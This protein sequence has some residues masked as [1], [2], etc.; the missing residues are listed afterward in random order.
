MQAC[1]LHKPA[2]WRHPRALHPCGPTAG[3]TVPEISAP[4]SLTSDAAAGAPGRG[5]AIAALVLLL[6]C[7]CQAQTPT[8]TL[9]GCVYGSAQI[10][11]GGASVHLR[12]ENRDETQSTVTDD[13]GCF[14]FANL[15]PDVY[16]VAAAKTGFH[17]GSDTI[18]LAP[19]QEGEI[20]IDL[21]PED[22]PQNA[23]ALRVA[24]EQREIR[25]DTSA[26]TDSVGRREL[27]AL[28]L[29]DDPLRIISQTAGMSLNLTEEGATVVNVG[30]ARS[31]N[32]NVFYDGFISLNPRTGSELIRPT[33]EALEAVKTKA[34]ANSAQYAK[35]AGLVATVVTKR[36]G[37][38]YH[39][40]LFAYFRNDILNARNYFD[41]TKPDNN[42]A[43]FGAVLGGPVRIP[44]LYQGRHRTFFF[45]AFE[46]FRES[47]GTTRI[48]GVPTALERQ[49]D[50]S[51]STGAGGVPVVL[52]D[53]FN[54]GAT[55]PGNQ[56]P[57]SLFSP[58]AQAVDSYFPL[59]NLPGNFNNYRATVTGIQRWANLL[60]KLDHRFSAA[61]E[62]SFRLQT[63]RA[64]QDVPFGGSDLGTFGNKTQSNTV[65][66]GMIWYHQFSTQFFNEVRASLQ[67]AT[68]RDW[69]DPGAPDFAAKSAL[70]VYTFTGMASFGYNSSV[71]GN[72]ATTYL[73]FADCAT[74]I[75]SR[76][77]LKWGGE[78]QPGQV[79]QS[80]T[81]NTRGTI[82][83]QDKT[84]TSKAYADFLMGLMRSSSIAASE[85]GNYV[86]AA[87]FGFFVQ[88]TYRLSSRLTLNLGLRY[89]RPGVL[90]EKSGR[91][92]SFLP[93]LGT[94]VTARPF[95]PGVPSAADLGLPESL[96]YP[97]NNGFTPRAGFG[98]HPFANR[99]LR[100]SA[101]WGMFL[102]TPSLNSIRQ[103][104][105]EA[106]PLLDI[107][108]STR[109]VVRS[110]H[111]ARL[112]R[113]R[114]IPI[115]SKVRY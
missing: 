106:P 58:L 15:S 2:T 55:F 99:S 81:K 87:T 51:Q 32:S 115:W 101:S 102:A 89:E 62:L 68:G 80:S 23:E 47:L 44:G 20:E 17:D 40:S 43:Q 5:A 100:V 82:V 95:E 114:S 42:R 13:R 19:E 79:N 104:M 1:Q 84:W 66:T 103:D 86:R 9:A 26:A 76:H 7:L 39:G 90:S 64:P 109:S 16:Q 34:D 38:Q 41:G 60:V 61:D 52:S 83:F 75:R 92:S 77:V 35:R 33:L 93:D 37:D 36:G 65:L 14:S 98:W 11:V 111:A 29:G 18:E 46:Y 71:P 30:G 74:W 3:S 56:I 31:E 94:Q 57:H 63:Q 49:G 113:N 28:P 107:W 59:P 108:K 91:W 27:R 105:A 4:E 50:Y 78:Y 6:A 96:R 69:L 54:P 21:V 110:D 22:T 112:R 48:S 24:V 88:D 45:G 12:S 53:P 73:E 10:P 70:P 25:S 97:N 67:R 8:A 85:E 72:W